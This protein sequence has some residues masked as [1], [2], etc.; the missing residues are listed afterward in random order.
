MSHK[1]I[2]TLHLK[3][4]YWEQIRDGE[5]TVELRTVEKWQPKIE[6]REYDEIHLWLGFPSKH[7]RNLRLIRKWR[8]YEKK[9]MQHDEFGPKPVWVYAIDV[10]EACTEGNE[11]NERRLF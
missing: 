5:K 4:K 11:G 3:R 1:K 7:R 9:F 10:S 6:G 2:L 8:G